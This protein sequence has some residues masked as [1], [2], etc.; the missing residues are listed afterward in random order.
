MMLGDAVGEE[1]N[2]ANIY[3]DTKIFA[4]I[5]I[6]AEVMRLTVAG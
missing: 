4:T 6:K 3:H 2:I 5:G 1:H